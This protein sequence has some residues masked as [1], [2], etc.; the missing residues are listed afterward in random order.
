MKIHPLFLCIMITLLFQKSFSQQLELMHIEPLEEVPSIYIPPACSP[1]DWIIIIN[2]A[3]DG[4]RFESNI[5]PDTAFKIVH[6]AEVN[7]YLICHERT[8]FILTVSGGSLRSEDKRLFDLNTIY[9]FNITSNIQRG[10]VNVR[11]SPPNTSIFFPSLNQTHS[12]ERPITLNTGN[13]PIT[14]TKERYQSLDTIV[15]FD[16]DT[17]S[18]FFALEPLF[19]Q[20]RLNLSTEDSKALKKAPNMVIHD[21]DRNTDYIVDLNYIVD[22]EARADLDYYEGVRYF[23]LYQNNVIPIPEGNYRIRIEAEKYIPFERRLYAEKGSTIDLPVSLNLVYGY[24]TF[25]DSLNARGAQIFINDQFAGDTV[26]KF[27]TRVPIGSNK[28]RFEKPGYKTQHKDYFVNVQED[29]N[30][31][32]YVA[33]NPWQKLTITSEPPGARIYFDGSVVTETPHTQEYPVGNYDLVLKMPNYSSHLHQLTF[34]T[35]YKHHDTLHFNLFQNYP[36]LIKSEGNQLNLHIKGLNHLQNIIV[37]NPNPIQNKRTRELRLPYGV[38]QIETR[39]TDHD[40]SYVTYKGKYY[41]HP[42]KR[43]RTIPS[44]SKSSFSF[45]TADYISENNMEA[46]FGRIHI[47]PFTGLSTAITNV[48]YAVFSMTDNNLVIKTDNTAPDPTVGYRTLIIHPIF[49]NWDWRLGGSIIRQ[50]DICLLTRAKWTPGTKVLGNTNLFN[51]HDATMFTYFYG[52]E[53]SSRLPGINVNLKIGQ[54]VMDGELH[55]WDK[56]KNEYLEPNPLFKVSEKDIIVSLGVTI[57]FSGVSRSNNMLRLWR[58]PLVHRAIDK[59]FPLF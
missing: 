49:L 22:R 46:S 11:T 13:Y 33:M 45:L 40:N 28:V 14:I 23:Q 48:N 4:L 39:T 17:T 44:Y 54:Q 8:R 18:Y 37:D 31:A 43:Q 30:T 53:V 16:R 38:Y 2:S 29:T 59:Y 10:T 6:I 47:F 41:H 32:F 58:K 35:E 51:Y 26:P 9:A 57:N 56:Q 12:S 52:L 5:M 1:E 24:I 20:L 36:L 3:I 34:N 50:L 25:I 7:Q 27:R 15:R 21:I 19:A 42:N 55:V